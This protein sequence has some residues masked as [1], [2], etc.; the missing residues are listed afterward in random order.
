MKLV[1]NSCFGGF[2]IPD[3]YSSEFDSPW[4]VKRN[5]LRLIELVEKLTREGKNAFT[6]STCLVV[7]E[8]PDEATDYMINDYDGQESVIYVVDGKLHVL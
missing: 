1:I 6:C 7:V 2:D 5:D 8:I 4:N 3:E